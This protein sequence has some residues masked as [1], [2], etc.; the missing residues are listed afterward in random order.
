MNKRTLRVFATAVIL[1][2]LCVP[3]M[4]HPGRTDKCGGH[5]DRSTGTYHYHSSPSKSSYSTSTATAKEPAA[6]VDQLIAE[7]QE[8]YLAAN[9][10]KAMA[11]CDN[12]KTA[13][14]IEAAEQS[15]EENSE[16]DPA[17]ISSPLTFDAGSGIMGTVSFPAA[18][19]Y[20]TAG[21]FPN[22]YTCGQITVDIPN[23]MNLDNKL[24]KV[25]EVCSLRHSHPRILRLLTCQREDRLRSKGLATQKLR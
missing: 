15:R 4:G 25:G 11:L 2:L 7:L 12:I 19:A 24:F 14:A 22:G 1:T 20:I 10:E 18:T 3:A 17:S 9:F 16:V 13:L 21:Y 23:A 6:T 8:A 5:Y